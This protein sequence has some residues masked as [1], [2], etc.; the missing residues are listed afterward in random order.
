MKKMIN[1][2]H[3]EGRVYESDLAV[4]VSKKG[5]T[6]I[7]GKLSVATDEAGLNVVDVNYSYVPEKY[8]SGSENKTFGV[9]K[10]LIETGKT[11][12]ANGKD[13]ATVVR[14]DSSIGLNEFFNANEKD[15]NGNPALIVAKRADSGF[16][17]IESD[18]NRLNSDEGKRNT[19]EVDMVINSCVR[20]DANEEKNIPEKVIVKGCVFNFR[21]DLLPIEL[22]VTNANGMN[23]F[24]DLGATPN[25]PKF[26][27]VWGRI[28]NETIVTTITE[29]SAFGEPV[30]KETTRNR[31]DWV[32][33]GTS[34]VPYE[35]DEEGVLTAD[36]L[37]ECLSNRQVHLATLRKNYDDY[38]AQKANKAESG[39]GSAAPK[40]ADGGF[41]F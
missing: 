6:Y 11:I 36:E 1:K 5:V 28:I 23:Y 29:E 33:T 16:A 24:E 40:V 26:T 41:D 32:I 8:N 7:G 2:V 25:T 21:N 10:Q 13:E 31:R 12:M 18:A 30:V 3:V 4:K 38:Q 20:L 19:F 14:L 17:H 37:K 9:L 34:T 35:F 15:E 22:S 27:K 39:F